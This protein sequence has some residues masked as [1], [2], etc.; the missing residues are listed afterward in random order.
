MHGPTRIGP[1]AE[2]PVLAGLDDE[3]YELQVEAWTRELER[4]GAAAI[5]LLY[6]HHLTPLNEAA[7]RALARHPGDRPRSTAP[8]C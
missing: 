4:A 2:D 6:L 8:S 3:A 7:A 5:D 1:A